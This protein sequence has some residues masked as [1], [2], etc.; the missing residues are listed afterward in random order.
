MHEDIIRQR[1]VPDF[2]I[3]ASYLRGKDSGLSFRGWYRKGYHYSIHSRICKGSQSIDYRNCSSGSD[4]VDALPDSVTAISYDSKLLGGRRL[5]A[6]RASSSAFR[7]EARRAK[8]KYARL[9][10][11]PW[12]QGQPTQ[13]EDDSFRLQVWK[14]LEGILLWGRANWK[15]LGESTAIKTD[16]LSDGVSLSDLQTSLVHGK[17]LVEGRENDAVTGISWVGGLV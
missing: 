7:L 9:S 3:V 13:R 11:Q 1:I 10:Q 17:P 6:I 8:L 16:M 12:K 14:K 2:A 15:G 5:D 4:Q